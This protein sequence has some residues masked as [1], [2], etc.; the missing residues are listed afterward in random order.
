M[1]QYDSAKS[2]RLVWDSMSSLLYRHIE[3]QVIKGQRDE[4]IPHKVTNLP[5][6]SGAS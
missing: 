3:M 5:T 4:V 6:A 2:Y 1:L